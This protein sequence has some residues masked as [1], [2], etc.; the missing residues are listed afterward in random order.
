M[1]NSEKYWRKREEEARKKHIKD[2]EE[3]RKKIE[4]IYRS[5]RNEI[6][7]QILAFYQKYASEEGLSM[8]EVKKK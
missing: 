4:A 6:S 7:D 3:Y 2:E 8:A 5:M 1:K